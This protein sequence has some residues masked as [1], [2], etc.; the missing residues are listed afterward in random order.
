MSDQSTEQGR[1]EQQRTRNFNPNEHLMQL[2]SR[3]GSKDYLPVQWRLVW[4]REKFP[5]GTIETEL[6]H[7]DLDRDTEEE[8]FVWNSEK[9]RSEKVM[10]HAKGVAVFKATVKDGM[11]GIATGVGSETA[12]AFG[13]YIEKAETKSI[14]RALAAL[15]FGTQFAGDEFNENHRIV[16]SPVDR[17]NAAANGTASNGAAASAV[18]EN[19]NGYAA[20]SDD[21]AVTEQQVTSIRKLCQHLGKSEPDNVTSISYL[22][23]RKLIAQLTNEYKASRQSSKA[24]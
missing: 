12:A 24:S 1:E 7:L 11:G 8:A 2:K 15:G 3:D 4:Y 19:G 10:K 23:A 9:K 22:A 18:A 5:H 16:D 14:G 21:S 13:D 20:P 6:V 17:S